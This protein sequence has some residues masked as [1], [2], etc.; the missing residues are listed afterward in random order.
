[1][2]IA[3]DT[4]RPMRVKIEAEFDVLDP[5]E[6]IRHWLTLE[7]ANEILCQEPEH[8]LNWAQCILDIMMENLD[9][10]NLGIRFDTSVCDKNP[11]P[12][13]YYQYS[14]DESFTPLE[15]EEV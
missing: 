9:E 8:S 11:D 13:F 7:H 4:S 6:L 15:V 12:H 14:E 10:E 5:A 1:M 2:K 3:V